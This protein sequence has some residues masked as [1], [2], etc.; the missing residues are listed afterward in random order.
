MTAPLLPVPTH[1]TRQTSDIVF[2][3]DSSLDDEATEKKLNENDAQMTDEEQEQHAEQDEPG[4]RSEA[5]PAPDTTA[6]DP[7]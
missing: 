4:T 2:S 7:K 5:D 3:D 6:S 1:P